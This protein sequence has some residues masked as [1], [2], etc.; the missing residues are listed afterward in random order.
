LTPDEL[1]MILGWQRILQPRI[2]G[3][4]V[5]KRLLTV[6]FVEKMAE[7][8]RRHNREFNPR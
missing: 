1:R 8:F 4:F 7:R 2:G 5:G 6:S 3:Y